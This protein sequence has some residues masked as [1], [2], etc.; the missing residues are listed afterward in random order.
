MMNYVTKTVSHCFFIS[1]LLNFVFFKYTIPRLRHLLLNGEV[2]ILFT[3]YFNKNP[4]TER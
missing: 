4:A 2:V 1:Y 3:E